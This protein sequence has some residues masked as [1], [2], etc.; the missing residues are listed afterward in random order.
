MCMPTLLAIE[1]VVMLIMHILYWR[2]ALISLQ[3]NAME[4]TQKGNRINFVNIIESTEKAISVH[5]LL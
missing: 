2:I 4:L 1:Q 3:C 5:I